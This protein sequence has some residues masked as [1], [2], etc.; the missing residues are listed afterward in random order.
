MNW[1]KAIKA[2]NTSKSYKNTNKI[3]KEYKNNWDGLKT[4]S[5]KQANKRINWWLSLMGFLRSLNKHRKLL[6]RWEQL[7][8]LKRRL[9]SNWGNF[10]KV[11]KIKFPDDKFN[12]K[13]HRN[14]S[15]LFKNSRMSLIMK[16]VIIHIW[17]ISL[18]QWKN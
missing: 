2:N 8:L 13:E 18:N 17:K 15:I 10:K 14:Y 11:L 3:L 16:E 5:F 6:D 4:I 9:K 1:R 7:E 12:R